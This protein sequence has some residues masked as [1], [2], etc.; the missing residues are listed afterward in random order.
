M[1]GHA[2][3]IETRVFS[4]TSGII[5]DAASYLLMRYSLKELVQLFRSGSPGQET[6]RKFS[7]INDWK[8]VLRKTL[9]SKITY[10]EVC[11]GFPAEVIEYLMGL[12][13][14][15]LELRNVPAEEIVRNFKSQ[16][17]DV[18]ARWFVT[19]HNTLLMKKRRVSKAS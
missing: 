17:M 13:K 6:E 19:A 4:D 2:H 10:F 5:K 11:D 15:A 12:M 1:P 16:E 9:I 7:K 8:E 14:E 3:Q 18:A